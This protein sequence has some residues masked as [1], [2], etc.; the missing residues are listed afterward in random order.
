M[1]TPLWGAA[2]PRLLG[3]VLLALVATGC[4]YYN[5]FYLAKRYYKEGQKAQERSLTETAPPEALAKYDATIRQCTKVITDYP[6]SKYV[7]DA[8][9]LLG[10][11]LYGKGDYGAAIRRLD[12]LRAKFPKSPFV[13]E[14]RFVQGLSYLKR[15]EYATADSI[16][17]DVDAAYPNFPRRWEL[18]FSEGE[19]KALQEDTPAALWWYR[20]A[21][22]A[23]SERHERSDALR[24]A[25]DALVQA[26]RLDS[27]Q[28]VYDDCLK[29][30]DRSDKRLDVALDRGAALRDLKRYTQALEFLNQWKSTAQA[31]NREG[32]LY[33]RVYELTALLGRAQDAIDG[34]KRLVE[35]YPH[36]NVAYEAQFQIGYLYESAVNDLDQAAKEYDK[37]RIEPESEFKSQAARRSSSLASLKQYRTALEADTTGA[38]ARSAFGVAELY[39]FELGKADSAM[40]QY[41]QVEREFPNSVFAPKSAYARLWITAFDRNDTLGAMGL[42]DSMAVKYRGTRFAESALYLWKR[43]SGRTDERTALLD[44]LM[45]HP[46]T[47]AAS[48]FVEEPEPTPAAG[49][50][51]AQAAPDSGYSLSAEELKRLQDQASKMRSRKQKQG[52]WVRP[53]ATFRPSRPGAGPDTSVAADD[54]V[55]AGEAAPGDS[56][57][58][59]QPAPSDSVRSGTGA[60]PGGATGPSGESPADTVKTII[61]GPNR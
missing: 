34:Y 51:T 6:K 45:A 28:A 18:Y 60:P 2:G 29:V 42:A 23:A 7:D 53:K 8:L 56:L 10:A 48:R 9:Y 5:T 22:G 33:L 58:A 3:I 47:S 54:S 50:A 55:E 14:A 38:R 19:N 4:A 13:P 12:E 26:D 32:E 49:A 21:I 20:R 1:R 16:F 15:K 11:S 35:K 40:I 52:P 36:T 44:S 43:W 41:R 39:Y 57:G 37:L 30:E 27:A 61:I 46:D 17:H 25:G 31:E 59:G 24:R